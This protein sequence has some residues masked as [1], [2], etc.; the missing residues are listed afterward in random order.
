MGATLGHKRKSMLRALRLGPSTEM[1]VATSA[2][3]PH[4]AS[5]PGAR[6]E[7]YAPG[8]GLPLFVQ[9]ADKALAT[10]PDNFRAWYWDHAE[11]IDAL[12]AHYG[13]LVFRGFAMQ[14]TEQF[15]ALV[16]GYE[17]PA[18]GYA[19][20]S[21]PRG[22]L[23][24]RVFEATSTPPQVQI[25]LHQEM[26][27]LPYHPARLAFFCRMPSITGGE[28]ILG[29]MARLPG[30]LDPDFVERIERLGVL[31]TRNLRDRSVSTGN[32]LLDAVHRTWQDAF[33][34]Q[35]PHEPVRQSQKLGLIARPCEDGSVDVIYRGPGVIRHPANG[36]RVWFNQLQTLNL[37]PHNTANYDL[38]E[39]TY[40]ATGRYP[41]A[42]TFGDGT[43]LAP[44][45][46]QA[47]ADA[48]DRCAV[49]FPWSGG[50][51][52]LIDNMQVAHGRNTFTGLRDV[53]VALLA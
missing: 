43:P 38:Y 17:R 46:A 8:R 50:D 3:L 49:A 34:T 12:L 48:V 14:S 44:Q 11:T 18:F 15:D 52:L 23:A 33:A 25:A 21:T 41:F 9:P 20:G 29:D 16:S 7:P 53:Q 35:D 47:L 27:Y 26:A 2:K 4:E 42:A 31:Y 10:D 32:S 40:A 13:A 51:V 45:E 5:L 36:R 28:T 19:A 30:L 1:D 37:G 39:Q 6:L 22:Q 24:E